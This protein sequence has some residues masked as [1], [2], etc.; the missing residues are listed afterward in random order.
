MGGLAAGACGFFL[1]RGLRFFARRF[2]AAACA[3]ASPGFFAF[4]RFGL[5]GVQPGLVLRRL[6]LRLRGG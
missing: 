4:L 1:Q 3:L 6:R 5:A 2:L